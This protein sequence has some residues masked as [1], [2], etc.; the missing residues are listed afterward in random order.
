VTSG[1][2]TRATLL[3]AIPSI[4]AFAISLAGTVD[5]A[6]DLVQEAM[7]RALA[8]IDGRRHANSQEQSFE[9]PRNEWSNLTC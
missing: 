3:K 8:T 5:R 7:L 2:D 4:R 1:S 6:D 9:G